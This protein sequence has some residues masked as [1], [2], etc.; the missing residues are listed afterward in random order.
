MGKGASNAVDDLLAKANPKTRGLAQRL[1]K[2]VQKTLPTVTEVVKW[3][4]PTYMVD[5]KNVAWMLL[6]RDHVDLG[7]FQ[8]ASLKSARLEGTG[9]GLR[10][11][12]VYRNDDVDEVEFAS[13]LKRGEALAKQAGQ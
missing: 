10:H 9:K 11:L 13:L 12:K 4:N 2:L 8:G 5:G 1:R 3:G 6:Y 7:F